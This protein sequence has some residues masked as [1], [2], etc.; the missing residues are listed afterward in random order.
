[1]RGAQTAVEAGAARGRPPPGVTSVVE[2]RPGGMLALVA[3]VIDRL[4]ELVDEVDDQ[5]DP[6]DKDELTD[7]TKHLAPFL[8]KTPTV[9][10]NG[11]CLNF[12]CSSSNTRAAA[13]T[14]RVITTA[15]AV[16]QGTDRAGQRNGGW[17]ARTRLHRISAVGVE[18]V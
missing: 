7:P 15:R 5:A 3:D 10:V 11:E 17:E 2:P 6:T 13:L 4:D 1:M 8:T 12:N 14:R 9:Y 16:V 18:Q